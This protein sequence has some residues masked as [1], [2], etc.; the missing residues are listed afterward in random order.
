VIEAAVATRYP[1]REP[2]PSLHRPPPSYDPAASTRTG[3]LI[4]RGKAFHYANAKDAMVIVLRELAASDASF[5]QRCSQHPDAQGRTRQYIAR[6]P[7]SSILLVQ[8]YAITENNY[9]EAGMSLQTST[10]F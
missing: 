5:L 1:Q 2:S 10:T 6:T 4:L 9:Q 8:T 7:K 3:T